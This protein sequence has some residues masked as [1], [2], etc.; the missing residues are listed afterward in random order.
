MLLPSAELWQ[1]TQTPY[2][3]QFASVG[4][5]LCFVCPVSEDIPPLGG[6]ANEE[7]QR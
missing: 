1:N 6:T 3:W 7:T 4:H 5:G 2:L